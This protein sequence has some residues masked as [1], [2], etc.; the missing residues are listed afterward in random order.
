MCLALAGCTE[1]KKGP[2]SADP[3]AT[4]FPSAEAAMSAAPAAAPT[5]AASAPASA[6][7]RGAAGAGNTPLLAHRDIVYTADISLR[8]KAKDVP[9]VVDNAVAA[10][11]KVGGVMFAQ[12]LQLDA[13]ADGEATATLTLKVP[14]DK[15]NRVLDDIATLGTETSRN[16]HADDVTSRVVDVTARIDA[17]KASLQRLND[18]K[19]HAGSITE[20][21]NVEDQVA[22]R[23]ADLESMEQ[24]QQALSSQVAQATITVTVT[25]TAAP[26]AVIHVKRTHVLGFVRGLRGGWHAFTR[27][28]AAAATALGAL[29][30]FLGTLGGVALALL[31]GRRYLRRWRAH[32]STRETL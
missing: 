25:G 13:K 24:Q 22:Q 30:P 3:A 20:L 29:L 27:T 31:L 18:L 26:V 11:Q 5:A 6:A 15:L 17:A 14:P 1:S 32:P 10:A 23:T 7:S 2:S 9:S 21:L 12:Q 28:V 4:E 16:V 8:T 19:Q